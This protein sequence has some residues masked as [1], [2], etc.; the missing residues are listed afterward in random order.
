MA[1]SYDGQYNGHFPNK[2]G[3]PIPNHGFN[4]H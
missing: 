3:L 2:K 4:L 1:H